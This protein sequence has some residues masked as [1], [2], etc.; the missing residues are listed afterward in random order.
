MTLSEACCN[1]NLKAVKL[2]VSQGLITNWD[3]SLYTVCRLGHLEIAQFLLSANP[4]QNK[5]PGF[6]GACRGGHL[7]ILKILTSDDENEFDWD[8]G[9]YS[10]CH[11]GHLNIVKYIVTRSNK[12]QRWGFGITCAC[13]QGHFDIAQ[14]L[15]LKAKEDKLDWSLEYYQWPRNQEKI[16]PLLYLK[17]PLDSFQNTRGFQDLGSLI[18][19]TRQA[20]IGQSSILLPDLL[21][22]VAQFIII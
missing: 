21:N 10:A 12:L 16:T 2:A 15:I 9:F 22:I 17:A 4:S 7:E 14:F 6:D 8:R 1:G 13:D 5:I 19:N 20:I 11:N 3:H 18:I